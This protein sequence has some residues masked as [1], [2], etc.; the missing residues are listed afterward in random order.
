MGADSN[1]ACRMCQLGSRRCFLPAPVQKCHPNLS[2]A[3]AIVV[4]VTV[5]AGDV[6]ID[7][8]AAVIK[9]DNSKLRFVP[10][11][12]RKSFVSAQYEEGESWQIRLQDFEQKTET[13]KSVWPQLSQDFPTPCGG[14]LVCWERRE[15]WENSSVLHDFHFWQKWFPKRAEK[16]TLYYEDVSQNFP[17]KKT[18]ILGKCLSTQGRIQDFGQ[19]AQRSFD[20]RGDPEPKIFSKLPDNCMILKIILGEGG[21]LGSACATSRENRFLHPV[22]SGVKPE[23]QLTACI[24]SFMYL[25]GTNLHWTHL[26]LDRVYC[27]T[28][29]VYLPAPVCLRSGGGISSP[30]PKIKFRITL[31]GVDTPQICWV[32][33]TCVGTRFVFFLKCSYK[34]QRVGKCP[35]I[36][37]SCQ[38][39]LL[40]RKNLENTQPQ[41]KHSENK[42]NPTNAKLQPA[43][44]AINQSKGTE[45][46][47]CSLVRFE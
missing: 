27:V 25:T 19:G 9:A 1:C 14:S 6:K 40:F 13:L 32:Q 2:A 4:T 34:N 16:K 42:E 44:R 22:F 24:F 12:I 15:I 37:W 30:Y 39:A 17:V 45:L 41:K 43:L 36:P 11:I 18:G 38:M 3:C 21:P 46:G 28:Q 10:C 23:R 33:D 47:N 8:G 26:E 5:S 29:S 35:G 31:K 20:P 7:P